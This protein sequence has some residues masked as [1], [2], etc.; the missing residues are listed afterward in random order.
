MR[1]PALEVRALAANLLAEEDRPAGDL[2]EIVQTVGGVRQSALWGRAAKARRRLVEVPFAL[3][4][5]REE[6]GLSEGPAEAVLQGAVDLVFEEDDGW[7]LIDYKSD[8]VTDNLRDL[9]AFYTPQV[10][11]YGQYW[12]RLTGQP[13]RTGLFFLQRREVVWVPPDST[14]SSDPL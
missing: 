6:L 10:R 2:D 12:Q 13:T 11:L 3:S 1:D 5:A 4:A 7:V 9:V 8:T 14:P